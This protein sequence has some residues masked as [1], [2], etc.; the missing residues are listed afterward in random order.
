MTKRLIQLLMLVAILF[1]TACGD[2]G[3]SYTKYDN[4]S[5]VPDCDSSRRGEHIYVLQEDEYEEWVCQYYPE[6]NDYYWND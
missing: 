1:I 5:A 3:T 6:Y 2:S 4:D